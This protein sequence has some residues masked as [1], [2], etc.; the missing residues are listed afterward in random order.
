MQTS[1]RQVDEARL[2]SLGGLFTEEEAV[3]MVQSAFRAQRARVELQG[4]VKERYRKQ[5]DQNT[6]QYYYINTRTMAG[7]S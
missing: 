5:W 3:R 2:V 4:L 6:R 7:R 1:L